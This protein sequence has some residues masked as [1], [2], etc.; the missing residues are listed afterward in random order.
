M[1]RPME[2]AA[3]SLV[4]VFLAA[5]TLTFLAGRLLVLEDRWGD[6][7][8]SGDGPLPAAALIA[9]VWDESW[10][11]VL[12]TDDH[13]TITLGRRATGSFSQTMQQGMEDWQ[14]YGVDNDGPIDLTLGFEGDGVALTLVARE[15]APGR[16]VSERSSIILSFG[17]DQYSAHA[18]EC[19]VELLELTFHQMPGR[20]FAIRNQIVTVPGF[21]GWIE[22]VDVPGRDGVATLTFRG[23]F[24][25]DP[26]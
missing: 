8:R 18:G 24:A 2:R 15:A 11:A 6:A 20:V 21:V 12:E 22:C 7:L 26:R 13:E 1:R 23:A 19:T 16:V 10:A 25:Y 14:I 17:G 5:M 9:S 3:V 4:G